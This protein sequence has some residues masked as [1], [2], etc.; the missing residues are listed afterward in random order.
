MPKNVFFML[1]LLSCCILENR[2]LKYM[3][4]L[5]HIKNY[6]LF[7]SKNDK[8]YFHLFNFFLER[9]IGTVE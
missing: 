8:D 3:N 2:N 5:K 7:H 4:K 9:V 6:E 1:N